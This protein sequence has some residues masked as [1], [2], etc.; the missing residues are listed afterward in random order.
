M[1]SSTA[2]GSDKAKQVFFATTDKHHSVSDKYTFYREPTPPPLPPPPMDFGSGAYN[3]AHRGAPPSSSTAGADFY[4]YKYD[5][6]APQAPI[7]RTETRGPLCGLRRRVFWAIFAAVLLILAIAVGVGVGVGVGAS[8]GSS[9][10]EPDS[11]ARYVH[12]D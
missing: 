8:N 6:V 3:D 7:P 2:V 4:D 5:H 1:H 12:S 9:N 11:Q 10:D